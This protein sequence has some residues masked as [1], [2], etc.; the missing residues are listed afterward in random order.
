[1][2][3]SVGYVQ[4]QEIYTDTHSKREYLF[5]GGVSLDR[6]KAKV[7]E[8]GEILWKPF[9]EMEQSDLLNCKKFVDEIFKHNLQFQI[10][11]YEPFF[12]ATITKEKFIFHNTETGMKTDYPIKILT[13]EQGIYL[14]FSNE[15]GNVFGVIF[16][17]WFTNSDTQP[18]CEFNI[19]ED[20]L[21]LFSAFLTV[22]NKTYRGCVRIVKK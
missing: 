19:P 7:H 15:K 20:E 13:G 1:V 14:M 18:F 12:N 17:E 3:L 2:L 10:E 6:Q 9:H 21:T 16:R 4:A 5:L 8:K 22:E 11:G